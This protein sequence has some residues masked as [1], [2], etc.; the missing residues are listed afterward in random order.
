MT[1]AALI[2]LGCALAFW[3][4]FDR[5]WPRV[6]AAIFTRVELALVAAACLAGALGWRRE[7][8]RASLATFGAALAGLGLYA[9]VALL[10]LRYTP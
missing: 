8:S 7:R 9:T 1:R 3:L 10:G 4:A 2:L 6:P 5:M